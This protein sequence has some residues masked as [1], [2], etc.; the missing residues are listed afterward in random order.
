MSQ[1]I[2]VLALTVTASGAVAGHRFVGFDGAQ[3]AASGGDAMGV[4]GHDAVDGQD[5]ALDVMGTSVVETA[6][7]VAVGDEV[8]SDA[9]GMAIT[10]PGVGGEIVLA[11]ALDSAA[12]AGEFIEVL[13]VR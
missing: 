11:R 7:A 12:G 9:S 10:N 1:K 8:V 2:V 5:L 4:A 3:V 13:L 6:G